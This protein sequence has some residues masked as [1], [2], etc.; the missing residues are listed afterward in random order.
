MLVLLTTLNYCLVLLDLGLLERGIPAYALEAFV[1]T[2]QQSLPLLIDLK[3]GFK[4]RI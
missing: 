4:S 1:E 2:S 3:I